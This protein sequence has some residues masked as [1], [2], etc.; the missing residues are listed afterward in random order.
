[1]LAE[2]GELR[3]FKIF[4]EL[5]DRELE[6]IAKIA[7]TEELGA[8]ARLTEAGATATNLYLVKDGLVTIYARGPHGRDVP[9]DYAGPGDVVGWSTVTGPYLYTAS[10]ATAERSALVVIN[11]NKLR[12]IFET[13]NHI[14]YRVLKGIGSV[15]ARR[16]AAIE[17]R[18][19]AHGG[20][21]K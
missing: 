12:Q 15:V 5:D 2:M 11:G 21:G 1:V 6:T 4:A 7:K 17:T 14:G 3:E 18:F 8:G 19:A 13:N 10:S 16:L 20:E 9:V